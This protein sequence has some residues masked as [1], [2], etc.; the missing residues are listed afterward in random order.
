[1][2][3]GGFKEFAFK[4]NRVYESDKLPTAH[5]CFNSLDLP[6]YS[7]MEILYDKLTKAII[8][9]NEGFGFI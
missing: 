7:S 3:H 6:N 1:M 5:T 2:P 9:G 4:I 8:E